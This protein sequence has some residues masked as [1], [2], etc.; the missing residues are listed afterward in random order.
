MLS[1]QRDAYQAHVMV[2]R[3]LSTNTIA[4][5]RR[6]L[7]RYVAFLEARGLN[8]VAQVTRDDVADF[9][10]SLGDAPVAPD[11]EVGA[12]LAPAAASRIVV[13]ARGFHKFAAL[14]GWT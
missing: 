6:D 9:A 5:Y 1:R 7:A 14:E 3:G 4:A 10:Q 13:S 12:V 2:E 8:D 11:G